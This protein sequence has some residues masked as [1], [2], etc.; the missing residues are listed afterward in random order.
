[1]LSEVV[2]L[3]LNEIEEIKRIILYKFAITAFKLTS[4]KVNAERITWYSNLDSKNRMILD[5]RVSLYISLVW[6]M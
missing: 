1:M 6:H 5:N 3:A 4:S 2:S